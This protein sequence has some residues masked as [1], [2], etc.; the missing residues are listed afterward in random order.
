MAWCLALLM[1]VSLSAW[2]ARRSGESMVV[3]V[4]SATVPPA[5]FPRLSIE[6]WLV[7]AAPGDWRVA[8]LSDN[9]AVLAIE[10]PDLLAQGLTFNRVAA[11]IEKKGGARERVLTDAELTA[12]V[13]RSGDNTET[14]YQGHDYTGIDL[15]RFYSLAAAQLLG[16]NAQELRL[17]R[18]LLQ[19]G[20][21]RESGPGTYVAVSRQA[22]ISFSAVQLDNPTTM[23]DESIDAQRRASVL[24]HEFSHGQFFTRHE[25]Q[26]SCWI[27]WNEVLDDAERQQFRAYLA[28]QDYD[29][30]N[31]ELMVNEVQALLMHTPDARAFNAAALG[32]GAT[33]LE[34]WRRRFPKADV[35]VAG[36]SAS[37]P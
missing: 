8:R 33:Q 36:K 29:A 13:A 31:E 17:L 9:E 20:V 27:F 12:L 23:Q 21:M 14:F 11:F 1:V 7:A 18:L 34:Q 35:S 5:E 3:A 37:S 22:V 32:V 2:L 6:A 16:L 26:K 10:F 25:Y 15:A 4:A 28:T 30:S 24:I 19:E